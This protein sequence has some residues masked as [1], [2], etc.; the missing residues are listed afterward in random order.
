MTADVT[1]NL[2]ATGA[3]LTGAYHID[4]PN[5]VMDGS[6]SGTISGSSVTMTFSPHGSATGTVSG[7][8]MTLQFFEDWG[9]G[10]GLNATFNLGKL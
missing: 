8:V 3:V 7:N 5:R 6:V 9:G 1:M 10:D 4:R 2:T